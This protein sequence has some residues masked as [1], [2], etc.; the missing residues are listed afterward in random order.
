MPN[1][2]N[3]SHLTAIARGDRPSLPVQWL[4]KEALGPRS[5]ILDYGCGKGADVRWLQSKGHHA[6]GYDPFFFPER[7]ALEER[8]EVVTCNYVINVIASE[9]ERIDTINS[10]LDALLPGGSC[11]VSIRSAK[12]IGPQGYRKQ[13]TYQGYHPGELRELGFNLVRRVTGYELHRKDKSNG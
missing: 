8:Y 7:F 10:C 9:G 4:A 1:K 6:A 11:F 5:K 12:C 2:K 3:K 13:G